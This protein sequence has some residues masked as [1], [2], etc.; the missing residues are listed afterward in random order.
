MNDIV[1][2]VAENTRGDKVGYD[3]YN[4]L[5]LQRR[6]GEYI[7][8]EVIG[9]P[10]G[11]TCSICNHGWKETPESLADQHWWHGYDEWVHLTCFIRYEALNERDTILCALIGAGFRFDGLKAIP[12]EYWAKGDPWNAKPWYTAQLLDFKSSFKIGHRKRVYHVELRLKDEYKDPSALS[13]FDKEEVTQGKTK[14][15]DFYIHAWTADKLRE[16]LK[17]F[18]KALGANRK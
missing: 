10:R 5:Y 3:Q 14:E 15:G 2:L 16:Y 6:C 8:G 17:V 7:I 1:R 4:Q 9:D 18:A 12:N 13:A 11:K